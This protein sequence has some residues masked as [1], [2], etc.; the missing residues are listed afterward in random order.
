M[1]GGLRYLPKYI[2]DAHLKEVA[3]RALGRPDGLA[4]LLHDQVKSA[5]GPSTTSSATDCGFSSKAGE[6]DSCHRRAPR[7]LRHLRL[8]GPVDLGAA[9]AVRVRAAKDAH[10]AATHLRGARVTRHPALSRAPAA[11]HPATRNR[12]LPTI[13]FLRALAR[14]GV[15]EAKPVKVNPGYKDPGG[16]GGGGKK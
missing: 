16:K 12:E 1:L 2:S 5:F 9:A 4:D 14:C 15:A 10:S 11:Q 7:G 8:R 3:C 6:A 13:G